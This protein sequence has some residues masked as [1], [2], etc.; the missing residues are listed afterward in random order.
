MKRA[1]DWPRY[2]TSKRLRDGRVAYYWEPR[3][4]D[5]EAGFTLPAEALGTDYAAACERATLLNAHLDD[6]RDGRDVPKDLA[7]RGRIGTVDWWVDQYLRSEAY[8][9]LAPRSQSDN[10]AALERLADLPTTMTGPDGTPLRVGTLPVSSLSPAAA[11]K[12]YA[13]LRDGGRITRQA[14]M[15]IDVARR[16]WNVV[17]R[18]YPGKFLVPVDGPEGKRPVRINPFE[19]MERTFTNNTTAP[20]T[21]AEAFAL[22]DALAAIG[23]PSLGAV[24]LIAFEWL[25]RPENV[26]GGHLTWSQYR[27]PH[28]PHSVEIFH[29]KTGE[30]IW[31]P[32]DDI[33]EDPETGETVVRPLYPEIEAWLARLPRL[34]VPVVMLQPQRGPKD[35][36]GRR[37]ARLYS[38]S[39]ADNLVQKA[40]TEAGLP[41]H[42]TFAACRHGGMT[43]LGDASVTEQGV[44]ALSGHR[45][46]NAARIYVKRTEKQRL[47]AARQRRDYLESNGLAEQ[48]GSASRN[49]RRNASRNGT[50][51]SR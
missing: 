12:L 51:E 38:E 29:H 5:R 50:L 10:K 39:Y 44:M 25:Q 9:R 42:V 4:R 48:T 14:N 32:L 16:A 22:A 37:P 3:K 47:A 45:T 1:A 34:G 49:G 30:R 7:A 26:I 28:R 2:M 6:W 41:S 36:S 33:R 40:R 35:A 20:A 18:A 23:H 17:A 31:Q 43:L 46:P 27:P 21:R 24:A 19:G 13:L 8:R 15:V 11:D